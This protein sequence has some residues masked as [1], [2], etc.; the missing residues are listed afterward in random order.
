[1]MDMP[2]K[3]YG[4]TEEDFLAALATPFDDLAEEEQLSAV[5]RTR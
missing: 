2:F 4:E 5:A 3:R 1:M